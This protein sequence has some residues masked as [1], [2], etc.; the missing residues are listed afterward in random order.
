MTLS[1]ALTTLRSSWKLIVATMLLC[2][3][4]AVYSTTS[5]TPMYRA[6]AR[7]YVAAQVND[8]NL[9]QAYQGG[10][11]SQQRIASY[12]AI[13]ASDTVVSQAVG[14]D[15]SGRK[16]DDV[17]KHISVSSPPNTVLLD[18][19]YTDPDPVIAQSTA[20]AVAQ[21]FAEY[22]TKLEVLGSNAPAV[23]VSVVQPAKLPK[24]PIS[25]RPRRDV[26]LG[27]LAGLALG[28]LAASLRKA[29]DR[30]VRSLDDIQRI[31]L[32]ALGA[33]PEDKVARRQPV[34]APSDTQS[35]RAEAFRQ[36][37]T[38]LLFLNIDEPLQS[39]LITSA[40]AQEGK[41]STVANLGLTLSHAGLSVVL[42]EADLRRPRLASMFGLE[43]AVGLTDVLIGAV[44]LDDALQSWHGG[45]LW[46]LPSG[47]LPLNPSELLNSQRAADLIVELESR[48]DLVLV[49]TPPVLPVTDATVLSAA[50][51]A[52]ALVVRNGRTRREQVRAA[53]AALQAVDTRV[54]G[55]I[56]NRTP[57]RGSDAYS[58]YYSNEQPRV[59]TH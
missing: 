34:L 16:I 7:L 19:A 50:V 23:R 48:F 13:V 32:P 55:V 54:S 24:Q 10:L 47:S 43:G 38:N 9:N 57:R 18:V 28:V 53:A 4:L 25:P 22:A 40:T 5:A 14:A 58:A 51:S 20:T 56:L 8:S 3:G 6:S 49:D 29:L 26:A 27:I 41:S 15:G 30:T 21:A 1:E 52:T 2:I 35:P 37:R 36:V 59:T 42:V 39:L 45:Q 44:A 17:E 31:G 46:V 11:L 12:S 33:I